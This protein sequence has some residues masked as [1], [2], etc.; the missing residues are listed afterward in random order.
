MVRLNHRRQF[1]ISAF[2]DDFSVDLLPG[3]IVPLNNQH[4]PIAGAER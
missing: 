4:D 3:I 1:F 2:G